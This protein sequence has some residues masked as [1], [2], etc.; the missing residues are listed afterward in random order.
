MLKKAKGMLNKDNKKL[1]YPQPKQKSK[2]GLPKMKKMNN[3]GQ[4]MIIGILVLIMSLIIFVATIPAV[5]SV[6]DD[7]KGCNYFNCAGFKDSSATSGETCSATN[8]TYNPSED[9]DTLACTIIDLAIPLLI[10]LVIS[11][12]AVKLISGNLVERQQPDPSYYG[13]Y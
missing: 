10:L 13:G 6:I 1:K 3:K 9:T 4:M 5:K 8:R 2:L 12:L 11:G 7:S